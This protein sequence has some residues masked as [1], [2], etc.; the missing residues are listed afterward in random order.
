VSVGTDVF[1][2][3]KV[4]AYASM[5]RK[6]AQREQEL[7]EGSGGPCL[8]GALH[9]GPDGP[10]YQGFDLDGHTYLVGTSYLLLLHIKRRDDAWSGIMS[11]LLASA[12]P[13]PLQERACSLQGYTVYTPGVPLLVRE[14]ETVGVLMRSLSVHCDVA[15]RRSPDRA[16]SPD[17]SASVGMLFTWAWH[18][19]WLWPGPRHARVARR[20]AG[21][22]RQHAARL[23]ARKPAA[24]HLELSYKQCKG[25]S[26]EAAATRPCR[27]AHGAMD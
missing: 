19:L 23:P 21:P 4:Q 9:S 22:A 3:Q 24:H 27:L 10:E 11:C 17:S 14:G 20:S 7:Q 16:L 5:T 18:A 1:P 8:L 2:R 15:V 26:C 25:C 13:R 12:Q 6:R